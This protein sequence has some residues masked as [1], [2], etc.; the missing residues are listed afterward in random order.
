M[1][2]GKIYRRGSIFIYISEQERERGERKRYSGWERGA[3]S[4]RQSGVVKRLRIGSTDCVWD[5]PLAIT[6]ARTPAKTFPPGLFWLFRC[7]YGLQA[8]IFVGL[9]WFFR[10]SW[11][12]SMHLQA[13]DRIL[14]RLV[15]I[16]NKYHLI[17]VRSNRTFC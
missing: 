13:C 10:C 3:S 4:R 15:N 8:R 16:S 11:V 6:R 9:L 14:Y 5:L 17:S 2:A 7:L 12:T 1:H